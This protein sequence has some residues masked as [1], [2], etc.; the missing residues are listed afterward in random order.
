MCD[1]G[2][3]DVQVN[4]PVGAVAEAWF[5]KVLILSEE[6]CPVKPVQNRQQVFVL[7]SGLRNLPSDLSERD[8]PPA[9]ECTLIVANVLVE[10]IHAARRLAR[11]PRNRP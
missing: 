5:E 7:D 4:Q 2:V 6:R 1:L 9:Q 8:S 10:E 11:R 3:S